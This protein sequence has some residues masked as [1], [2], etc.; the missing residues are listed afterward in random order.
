MIEV[1]KF[2]DGSVLEVPESWIKCIEKK[3]NIDFEEWWGRV[4]VEGELNEQWRRGIL[5]PGYG[6][7]EDA[8]LGA[9]LYDWHW[10]RNR[11]E[12]AKLYIKGFIN[13]Y[14]LE[15]AAREL[16][17]ELEN[18]L[19]VAPA[20][21]SVRLI[22]RYVVY[23]S[24]KLLTRGVSMH[25]NTLADKLLKEGYST[26]REKPKIRR[27]RAVKRIRMRDGSVFSVLDVWPSCIEQK[28]GI[29]FDKYWRRVK[30]LIEYMWDRKLI[31]GA[32]GITDFA[33]A[34]YYKWIDEGIQGLAHLCIDEDLDG[35][36]GHIYYT[37]L[38]KMFETVYVSIE[39]D[40]LC[41]YEKLKKLEELGSL[42]SFIEKYGI[43][44]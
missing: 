21:G 20:S 29:S 30:P 36:R 23:R 24:G 39:R 11:A 28:Y 43:Y 40:K 10:W 34:K 9:D 6:V 31:F 18:T 41:V 8:Y 17:L 7:L 19:I 13:S 37:R 16:S 38:Y 22:L 1:E 15:Q 44:G 4:K 33:L 42:N 25:L 32:A 35:Y 14:I 3:N 26:R 27:V 12:H 5:F 2:E